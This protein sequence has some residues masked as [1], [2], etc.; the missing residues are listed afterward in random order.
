MVHRAEESA[1][2]R[3][4]RKS[5]D[6]VATQLRRRGITDRRVLDAMAKVP[7]ERF[8]PRAQRPSAYD[9]RALPIG[10]G[11]T[12]SQPYMVAAMLQAL[13][14]GPELTALEIGG[15]SGYQAALLGEL[16]ERVWAVEIVEVLADRAGAVLAE[17]GYD[18]VEVV[19]GDGSLGLPEHA[20]YDRIIVAAGAPEVP[21]PLMEQLADGGRL[22]A[23]VG[24]RF[25]QRLVVC[26][27]RGA[28]VHHKDGMACIFV[29]LV[30]EHGWRG[31]AG[32]GQ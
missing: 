17:L 31:T 7:R 19:A 1:D 26:V 10:E 21:E 12:I 27:R 32:N 5:A 2:G 11:Q 25:S 6:M 8:V 3:F 22:V 18:N 24:G 16:C 23:P 13:R 20:P 4:A 30:G 29:P 28:G 15:G 9:D 14:T